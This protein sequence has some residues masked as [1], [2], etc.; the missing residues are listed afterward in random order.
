[1][2][3]ETEAMCTA[4]QLCPDSA[5]W[6][7]PLTGHPTGQARAVVVVGKTPHGPEL[8]TGLVQAQQG[9]PCARSL[10]APVLQL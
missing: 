3:G 9:D 5:W 2:K 7:V 8:G 4:P 10:C 6:Q 1:M